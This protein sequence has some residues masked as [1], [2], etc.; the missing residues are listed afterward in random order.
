MPPGEGA[1]RIAIPTAMLSPKVILFN[2]AAAALIVTW[3]KVAPGLLERSVPKIAPAAPASRV[4][5]EF[6]L[7][8][9]R[10]ERVSRADLLG[11]V[12]VANFI[13]SSCPGPCLDLTKRMRAIDEA[14]ADVE[15]LRIVTFSI[16][17]KLDTPAALA[18]YAARVQAGP[19]WHFLTGQRA[20]TARVANEGFRFELSSDPGNFAHSDHVVVVDKTGTTRG[21][22]DGHAP[23]LVQDVRRLVETL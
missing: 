2:A 23:D 19:R 4:V 15:A 18:A 12:W 6:A 11:K 14:L 22:F 8:D 17:E 9:H 1:G 7:P 3:I 16:D 13:F 5:P 21:T 20:I 10:G